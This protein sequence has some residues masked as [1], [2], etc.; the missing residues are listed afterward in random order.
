MRFSA[1]FSPGLDPV[2]DRGERDEDAMVSPKAPTGGAIRQGVLH[3]QLHGQ[4]N[5]AVRVV[6]ARRSQCRHVRVE[7]L[8][9]LGTIMHRIGELNVVW[10]SREEIAQIMKRSMRSP[11]SITT[12]STACAGTTTMTAT[13]LNDLRLGKIFGGCDAFGSIRNVLAWACHDGALLGNDPLLCLGREIYSKS[14]IVSSSKPE[15]FAT[16]SEFLGWCELRHIDAPSRWI[17]GLSKVSNGT[18]NRIHTTGSR[19]QNRSNYHPRSERHKATF[20][21]Q[22]KIKAADRQVPA[23]KRSGLLKKSDLCWRFMADS[24]F[25][26]VGWSC[27]LCIARQA[28]PT[29]YQSVIKWEEQALEVLHNR[30]RL[31]RSALTSLPDYFS[32]C[33]A[34]P[35]VRSTRH[36]PH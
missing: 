30:A 7:V 21:R 9:A 27:M 34:R 17:P 32:T 15:S 10:P 26:R 11:I 1:F 14:R 35:S 24:L 3:D 5:H 16:V 2:L 8:P 29:S 6:T 33:P 36:H 22:P 20:P 18:A 19:R 12:M 4:I 25:H 13:T 31:H 23:R 28:L